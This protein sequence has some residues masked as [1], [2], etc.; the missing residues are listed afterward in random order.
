MDYLVVCKPPRH[1]Q[2][3][4]SLEEAMAA[5]TVI[6]PAALRTTR[7]R[8]QEVTVYDRRRRSHDEG[9]RNYSP[10]LKIAITGS[11][12]PAAQEDTRNER[13]E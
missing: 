10:L 4:E 11:P 2:E 9:R 7:G 8:P 5:L 12:Q 1:E 6:L 3:F 13:V